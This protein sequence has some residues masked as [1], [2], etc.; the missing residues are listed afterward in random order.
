MHRPPAPPAERSRA[1]RRRWL[2][3]GRT[4][5]VPLLLAALVTAGSPGW[6]S[7]TIKRGDTLARS[8]TVTAR[9]SAAWSR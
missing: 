1:T 7:Y 8:R 4:V 6:G 2:R 3:L 5:A 9:P